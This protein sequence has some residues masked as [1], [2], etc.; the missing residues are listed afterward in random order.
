MSGLKL[1]SGARPNDEKLEIRFAVGFGSL[2]IWL[3]HVIVTAPAA[4]RPLIR[5]PLSAEIATTGIV[6][7]G[8]PATVGETNPAALL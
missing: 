8:V 6:I 4:R 2:T 7:A 5:A 3:V 1:R